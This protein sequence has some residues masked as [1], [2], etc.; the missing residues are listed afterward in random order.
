MRIS[1]AFLLL[2]EPYFT[3]SGEVGEGTESEKPSADQ[4]L[5]AAKSNPCKSSG[6]GEIP[7]KSLPADPPTSPPIFSQDSEDAASA[8]ASG[9]EER[10]GGCHTSPQSFYSPVRGRSYPHPGSPRGWVSAAAIPA[11]WVGSQPTCCTSDFHH[12][13]ASL[14]PPYGRGGGGCVRQSGDSSLSSEPLSRA[15]SSSAAVGSFAGSAV[16]AAPKEQCVR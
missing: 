13:G 2:P 15:A 3:C 11:T 12:S 9:Q 8:A 6:D 1:A 16:P 10:A 14:L 5:L 4:G 7:A